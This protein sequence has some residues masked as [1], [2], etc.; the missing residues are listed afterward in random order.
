MK[1]VLWIMTVLFLVGCAKEEGEGGNSSISGKVNLEQYNST[2][3]ILN[4]TTAAADYDVFIVYGDDVGFSD[5]TETDYKGEFTFPF[6]REGDYTIYV[7]SKVNSS[8]AINGQAP[9]EEAIIQTI[10][11]SKKEDAT[12][13]DFTVL[14]N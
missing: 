2:F 9:S 13:P 6:L 8:E 14:N 1:R 4:Y 5:N 7:Y 10:S 3:T 12:L 11:I